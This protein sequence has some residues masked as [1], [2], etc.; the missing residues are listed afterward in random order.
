MGVNN[1]NMR[2]LQIIYPLT[3]SNLGHHFTTAA[4]HAVAASTRPA[5]CGTI[6]PVNR[7]RDIARVV[8][9]PI[10]GASDPCHVTGNV[11]G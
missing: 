2:M 7:S 6:Q 1:V 8:A 11:S 9:W 3:E 10:C 5:V 4:A